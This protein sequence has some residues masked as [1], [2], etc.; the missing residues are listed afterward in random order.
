MF[1]VVVPVFVVLSVG[2]AVPPCLGARCQSSSFVNVVPIVR[3]RAVEVSS[4]GL[5][6]RRFLLSFAA[7]RASLRPSLRSVRLLPSVHSTHVSLSLLITIVLCFV[8][9]RRRTI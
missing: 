4:G 9:C 7:Q 3:R 6:L 1:A 2:I 5:Y 8:I